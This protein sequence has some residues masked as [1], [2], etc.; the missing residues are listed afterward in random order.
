MLLAHA[1]VVVWC[2]VGVFNKHQTH[3][4]QK[5][6]TECEPQPSIIIV[7]MALC[8]MVSCALRR[9]VAHIV[10]ISDVLVQC[11]ALGWVYKVLCVGFVASCGVVV[12]HLRGVLCYSC[13]KLKSL[14]SYLIDSCRNT[15]KHKHLHKGT[16]YNTPRNPEGSRAEPS[17][18]YYQPFTPQHPTQMRRAA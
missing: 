6:W 16:L 3:W 9:N 7:I 15:H 8:V 12:Q 2:C 13:R 1:V 10:H 18:N 17:M 4:E 14:V 5:F 11:C